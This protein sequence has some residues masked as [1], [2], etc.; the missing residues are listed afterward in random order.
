MLHTVTAAI[1]AA[2][3]T[4]GLGGYFYD[5]QE[6][7]R[8]GAVR[9]GE[10]YRGEPVTPG[11][12][13]VRMPA[14]AL[15]VGFG[16]RGT[17]VWGDGMSVQYA[18]AAGRDAVLDP[19]A[20]LP[21]LRERFGPA[22]L[23]A[24]VRSFREADARARA[25]LREL[26][27]AHVAV[28]YA[29]SQA[30]LRAAAEAGGV[31]MAEVLCAEYGLPLV[32]RAVPIYSQSGDNRR[33]NVDKMIAK[34]VDVMPHGLIN[35]P[36]KFE[37]L[38][39]YLA[40]V[41]DRVFAQEGYRPTL[42]IDLYGMAG[43]MLGTATAVVADYLEGL[44]AI[45]RPFALRIE[46]PVD[47]GSRDAQLAGLAAL[48]AEL[49]ARGSGIEVVADEWCNTLDDVREF[50][51][52]R[53]GHMLQVK[54]PDLGSLEHTMEALDLCRTHGMAAFLGGSCTE[55]DLSA[56]V[57][58]HVAVAT[59]PAFQLA[60]PGMGVDEALMIAHNE[61]Q[62]L[63]ARVNGLTERPPFQPRPGT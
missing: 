30:L 45:A 61:Q 18:S 47:H 10:R 40:W 50:A 49:D 23:G 11:F 29:V 59:Q 63:L 33:D 58:V 44:G 19:G 62:R 42:H 15:L 7:I 41:R 38:P 48:R 14:R 52:A 54:V 56:Q 21:V 32:A 27:V 37:A 31:T 46:S 5:D 22:M 55:T 20:L 4:E 3:F 8:R 57:C 43:R 39:G 53:A 34:R 36:E 60:K 28:D 25:L 6:A 17:F 24:D 26:G 35:A 16:L 51:R 12:D 1:T 2:R 13:A 9:D